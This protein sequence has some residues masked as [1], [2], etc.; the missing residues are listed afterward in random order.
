MKNVSKCKLMIMGNC[1]YA[2]QVRTPF[3]EELFKLSEELKDR[4][5]FTGYI[6]NKELYK[7]HNIS[8]IA[9]IPSIFEEPF[10]LTVIE[11]MASGLPL[12]T[13]DAG[14]I[15]DIVDDKNAIIVERGDNF[16]PNLSKALDKLV[17][18]KELREKMGKHSEELVQ[19]Y[20][21]PN[22]YNNFCKILSELK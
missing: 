19:D 10:G 7:I 4:I 20:D 2:K 15:P 16:I 6:A 21:T 5:I 9:V 22:Y 3:E 17:C 8:D 11:A 12:V 14:A 13:S 18:D 1:N